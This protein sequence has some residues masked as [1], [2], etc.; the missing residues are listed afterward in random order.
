MDEP[1]ETILAHIA[2][3][4]HSLFPV[5]RGD[6]DHIEGIVAAKE[7]LVDLV[8]DKTCDL[9]AR[10]QKPL[11]IPETLTVTE[12]LRAFK[13]HRQTMALI[14]N[15]YGELPGAGHA[16]RRARSAGGR[17]CAG[18][19][20]RGPGHRA[21]AKTARCWSTAASASSASSRR[22]ESRSSCRRRTPAATTRSP[23]SSCCSSGACPR[24]PITSNGGRALRS[25]R[26]GPQPRGPAPRDAP[27]AAAPAAP[28]G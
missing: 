12:V 6:L 25:R 4:P 9:K 21:G 8:R 2:E 18:G 5:T 1:Q 13:L 22:S 14:V 10:L 24:R 27:S 3:A 15:E 23:V 19:R 17:H 16:A 26:H 20:G 7:L 11:Y 28:L